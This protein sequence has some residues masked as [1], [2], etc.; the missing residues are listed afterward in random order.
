MRNNHRKSKGIWVAIHKKSSKKR[1]IR[2]EEAVEE[3]VCFGWIDSKMRSFDENRF[4]QRFSPRKSGSVWSELNKNR[5]L[6]MIRAGKMT[7]AG[8]ETIEE[9]K[10]NGKW[11]EAYSSRKV[12]VPQDVADALKENGSAWKEFSEL[13]NS[14]R[15]QYVFWIGQAKKPETRERRIGELIERLR[16]GFRSL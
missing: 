10:V 16:D 6:Q 5:A 1:S 12:T 3:A 9:A 4:I 2:Y 14:L 15:L 7:K 11:K 13:P 8:L